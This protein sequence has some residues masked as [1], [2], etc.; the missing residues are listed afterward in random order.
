[1]VTKHKKDQKNKKK[2]KVKM[3]T[4]TNKRRKWRKRVM[5]EGVREIMEQMRMKGRENNI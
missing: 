5:E 1:M 4:M 3:T 2:R